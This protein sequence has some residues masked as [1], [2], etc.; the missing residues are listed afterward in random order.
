[1]SR[2]VYR[3]LNEINSPSELKKLTLDQLPLYC[4]EVRDFIV[5]CLADNSGHLGASLGA[6]EI[7]VALHYVF[8]TPDDRL[9]WDVGHQA[10]AHK[11]HNGPTRRFPDAPQKGAASEDFRAAAKVPTTLSWADTHRSP[12]RP[13]LVWP[14]R[15]SC[16][17]WPAM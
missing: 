7:A 16:R 3:F 9:I 17:V 13:R 12:Y 5:R 4:A 2:P 1:M 8:D 10:Y 6:V 14:R 15:T 11:I